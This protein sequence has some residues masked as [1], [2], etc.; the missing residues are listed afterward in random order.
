MR[1]A[2]AVCLGAVMLATSTPAGAAPPRSGGPE[3][4]MAWSPDGQWLAYSTRVDPGPGGIRFR[5]GWL[6][7]LAAAPRPDAPTPGDASEAAPRD[8][9]WLT[10]VADGASFLVDEAAGWHIGPAWSPDSRAVA[11]G[12]ASDDGRRVEVVVWEARDR[13]RVI[14]SGAMPDAAD[15]RRRVVDEGISWSG[16]GRYLA[17]PRVDAPGLA[18]IR[19]GDGK[20]VN[21]VR[22]GFRPAWSPDGAKLACFVAGPTGPSLVTLESPVGAPRTLIAVDHAGQPPIWTRDGL[23]ILDRNPVPV[24]APA[25]ARFGASL[26]LLRV[27]FDTGQT[28][29]VFPIGAEPGPSLPELHEGF[30]FSIDREGDNLFWAWAREGTGTGTGRL[31]VV[32]ARPREGMVRSRFPLVPPLPV[33]AVA[34]QPGGD[35]VALQLGPDDAAL[36]PLVFSREHGDVEPRPLVPDDSSRTAWL[37][38]LVRW[39]AAATRAPL[40]PGD[41]LRNQPTLVPYPVWAR[42]TDLPQKLRQIATLAR[43]L[44]DR[45]R[46]ADPL[47]ADQAAF[48]DEARL[49]FAALVDDFTAAEAALPAVEARAETAEQRLGL[50]GLRAQLALSRG[51]RVRADQIV[52]FLREIQPRPASRLEWVGET[53]H[54]APTG[55][56]GPVWLAELTRLVEAR[57]A[58]ASEGNVDEL[59]ADRLRESIR[60]RSTMPGTRRVLNPFTGNGQIPPAPM[61][62]GAPDGP[63][64][65]QPP[66]RV[67]ALPPGGPPILNRAQPPQRPGAPKGR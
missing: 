18:V 49:L 40:A 33:V 25:A 46:D 31:P 3:S 36:P 56:T 22:N 8:R 10:R 65:I 48:L 20:P 17:V 11:F 39:V 45:P 13:R 60:R 37:E 6:V 62:F 55:T 15:L 50:I 26:L 5:P 23:V 66:P 29:P 35:L 19:A 30:S 58:N 38:S 32:W 44:G 57:E 43:T 42:P 14:Q 52:R 63:V 53:P 28:E 47:P 1:P 4:T 61:R 2:L 34:A 67:P 54:L 16:D 12:R 21:L 7:D 64:F 51:D 27:R 59:A 24:V 9:L 41:A